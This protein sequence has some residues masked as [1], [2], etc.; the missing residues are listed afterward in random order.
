M[1]Y[2]MYFHGGQALH[3]SYE[4]VNGNISHGCVRLHVNDARWLRFNF[5]EPGT[6]VIIKPY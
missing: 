2:C 1:P 5:A 4:V 3:G 6:K